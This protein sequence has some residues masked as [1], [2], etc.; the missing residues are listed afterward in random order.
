[1]KHVLLVGCC[2]LMVTMMPVAADDKVPEAAAPSA[3]QALCDH[4]THTQ[5]KIL[6]DTNGSQ[7]AWSDGIILEAAPNFSRPLQQMI[8]SPT[9]HHN[10]HAQIRRLERALGDDWKV[11]KI[12]P[13]AN[14]KGLRTITASDRSVSVL[15]NTLYLDYAMHRYPTAAS[16]IKSKDDPILIRVEG[17]IRV[18]IMPIDP[19][20]AK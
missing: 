6:V 11:A 14:S 15:V 9:K 18:V 10:L 3:V 8:Q 2:V 16:F 1:M 19:G 20:L 4:I 13:A 5:R 7:I 17:K 12:A